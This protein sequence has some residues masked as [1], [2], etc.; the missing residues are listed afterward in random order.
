LLIISTGAIHIFAPPIIQAL[1]TRYWQT[2]QD[3]AKALQAGANNENLKCN[4][5]KD[6]VFYSEAI[7]GFIASQAY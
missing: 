3:D 6:L 7:A 2:E 4:H 5:I 1:Q